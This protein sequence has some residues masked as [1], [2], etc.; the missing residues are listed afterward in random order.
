MGSGVAGLLRKKYPMIFSPYFS[1]V[2]AHIKSGEKEEIL[3]TIN[4]VPVTNS[5]RV[6]N[7]FT[8]YNYGYAGQRYT[9]YDA[10]K[11]A[12][13]RLKMVNIKKLPVYIPYQYGC[14]L[15][16]GDW[17]VVQSIIESV[18]PEVIVCRLEEDKI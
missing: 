1:V 6:A 9:D 8:Q 7:M 12:F 13:S 17:K 14:G 15:G 18:Y 16:G 11:K 4:I 2:N 5:L 3:G 10:I